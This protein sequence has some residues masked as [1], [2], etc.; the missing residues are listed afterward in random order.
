M[1]DGDQGKDVGRGERQGR[2]SFGETS[3]SGKMLEWDGQAA[4]EVLSHQEVEVSV[5]PPLLL[6]EVL[7]DRFGHVR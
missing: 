3:P 4:K 1:S 6:S 7:V 5:I 2:R